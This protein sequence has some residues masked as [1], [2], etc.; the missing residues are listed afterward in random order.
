MFYVRSILTIEK[1]SPFFVIIM[2]ANHSV[3]AKYVLSALFV[4]IFNKTDYFINA[5]KFLISVILLH[6]FLS[7]C[8]LS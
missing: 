5:D 6:L 1:Y 7:E 2:L 8:S 4:L 3:K